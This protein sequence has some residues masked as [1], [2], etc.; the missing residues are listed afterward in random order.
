MDVFCQKKISIFGLKKK[1]T[2][3]MQVIC[4]TKLTVLF[5]TFQSKHDCYFNKNIL[6]AKYTDKTEEVVVISHHF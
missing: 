4:K 6:C 1:Y 5:I 3:K 2:T